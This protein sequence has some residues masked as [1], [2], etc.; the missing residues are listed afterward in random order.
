MAD[1]Q[2]QLPV[3]LTDG[4]NT[5]AITAASAIKVDGS[6]VT[7]PISG[8]ITVTPTGTQTIT[9]TVATTST[10][11]IGTAH[12]ASA[13]GV[14]LLA[15]RNDNATTTLNATN[16]TYGAI[17][18][19]SQGRVLISGTITNSP[20]GTQSVLVTNT[21]TTVYSGTQTVTVN[22]GTITSIPSGIQTVTGSIT[23][24]PSGIQA[25]SGSVTSIPSGTQTVAGTIT[26]V[27]SGT[28]TVAVTGTMTSADHKVQ[29]TA[30]SGT[31]TGG[32]ILAV[33]ND[34][35]SSTLNPTNLRY[36]VI[37][38]DEGGRVLVG[39]SLSVTPTGTQTIVG[40]VTSVPSG[41]Q[42]IAGAVTSVPSGTQT[43][44]GSVT[45]VPS[46]TQTVTGTLVD[47]ANKT[48]ASA[49]SG[50]PTGAFILAVRNDNAATTLNPTNQSY[51]ALAVDSQ[52]RLLISGSITA[53]P[54]GGT[55]TVAVINTVTTTYSGTQTVHVGSGSL[56]TVPS[57]TQAV[58]GSVTA[59]PSGTQNVNISS[60]S[61][62][63]VPSGVQTVVGS[64][65]SI[66]SGTQTVHMGSGS[67]TAVPSGTQ[68][69]AGSVTAIPSGTQTVTGTITTSPAA[70]IS[71]GIVTAYGTA[72]SVANGSTGTISYTVSAGKT[73][74]LK[75]II[76]SSSGAPC[77]VTLDYGA[78][79]TV[80]CVGFYAASNPT[81]VIPFKQPIGLAAGTALNIKIA[82]FAG[83]AQ[84]LYATFIGREV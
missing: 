31:P 48:L 29:D 82:N 15:V 18:V 43:I 40:S 26:S 51:G 80:I 77:K 61:I 25:V 4:T 66:P 27:P 71:T 64:V 10:K 21:V 16:N 14:L 36:G 11:I 52:G 32:L 38:V 81:L 23:S 69:V 54:G 20:T 45:A 53:T 17:A 55:Q 8:T 67:I 13:A 22:N 74:Y 2:T 34:G 35:G 58:S 44:T 41:T 1:I 76:A 30:F 50:M 84:D 46:G 78:G 62:T 72:A 3:K 63:A 6:G 7:Q 59:I 57:G 70:E 9:G 83:Q 24:V 56:T 68:T 42:T 75:Q 60:G 73:L 12:G 49:F 47:P 79:P 65:T 28:Q 37:A 39:G 19:D 33:R 5:A